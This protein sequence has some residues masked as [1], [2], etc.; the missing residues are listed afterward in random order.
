M[1]SLQSLH[2][3]DRLN[4]RVFLGGAGGGLGSAALASLMRPA[5]AEAAAAARPAFPNFP[6]KAKRIIY[7]FQ[8]GGP[9]QMESFDYKPR[10][11]ADHGKPALFQRVGSVEQ[12][13]VGTMRLFGS[14]WQFA[15]HGDAGTWASDLFPNIA[16]VID[17]IAVLDDIVG[18]DLAVVAIP[19]GDAA[20]VVR[21]LL[22]AGAAVV[23]DV[24]S[25]KA[26]IAGSIED[27]RFVAGHPMAGSE[28][29]GGEDGGDGHQAKGDVE[30]VDHVA[31]L[32]HCRDHDHQKVKP[33][34]GQ[35][36]SL[37]EKKTSALHDVIGKTEHG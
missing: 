18:C 4:R 37:A 12:P 14:S 19:V 23:T 20:E 22:D 8:S 16:G 25:V 17:D 31:H 10:L 13:G 34:H 28:Q 5:P 2:L 24:G 30:E 29:D 26:A 35:A 33:E 11:N 9:S 7:L 6:P 36:G 15:Q 3:Q 27:P 21:H 32:D 1:R